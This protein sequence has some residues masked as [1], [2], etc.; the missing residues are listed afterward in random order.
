MWHFVDIEVVYLTF[1]VF[2][3]VNEVMSAQLSPPYTVMLYSS[4]PIVLLVGPT[5]AEL[6]LRDSSGTR[7]DLGICLG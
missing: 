7:E 5:Q 4:P 6:G 1:L 3:L 2:G